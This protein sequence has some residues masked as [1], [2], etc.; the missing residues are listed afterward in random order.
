MEFE[1]IQTTDY[2]SIRQPISG[3]HMG[4]EAQRVWTV[5]LK[6]GPSS[7]WTSLKRYK[8]FEAAHKAATRINKKHSTASQTKEAP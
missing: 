6:L 3:Y 5:R 1:A 4:Y 7:F 8:D 2:E